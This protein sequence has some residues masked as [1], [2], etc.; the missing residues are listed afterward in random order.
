MDLLTRQIMIHKRQRLANDNDEVFEDNKRLFYFFSIALL[1]LL[2]Q[3]T[4]MKSISYISL[5]A[6]ISIVTALL[7]IILN[8]IDEIVHHNQDLTLKLYDFSGIPY[9]YGIASFMFEGN[10]V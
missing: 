2:S 1:A 9:F 5:I 10:A 3:F 7:Y 6:I 8:D 4:S